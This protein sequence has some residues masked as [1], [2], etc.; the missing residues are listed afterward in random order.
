MAC[1]VHLGR[2]VDV[3][4]VFCL[5]VG[6]FSPRFLWIPCDSG[7]KPSLF[8]RGDD[9]D[10]L[11]SFKVLWR[12]CLSTFTVLLSIFLVESWVLRRF[13]RRLPFHLFVWSACFFGFVPLFSTVEPGGLTKR[14]MLLDPFTLFSYCGRTVGGLHSGGHC[15][16]WYGFNY[17]YGGNA[18]LVP[19]PGVRSVCRSGELCEV[20]HASDPS[21]F[22]SGQSWHYVL[23]GS[24]VFV[25][26]KNVLTFG[27]HRAA[28]EHFGFE[29]LTYQCGG[30]LSSAFSAA[31]SSGYDAVQFAYHEDAT[32]GSYLAEL[33]IRGNGSDVCSPHYVSS[34]GKRCACEPSLGYAN[35]GAGFYDG[36]LYEPPEGLLYCVPFGASFLLAS[37]IFSVH[38]FIKFRN[39]KN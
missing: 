11:W 19:S 12:L 29:C 20:M 34:N 22:S 13:L 32:C 16:V 38:R 3:S 17:R 14:V 31:W 36:P 6:L 26:P 15:R 24:G 30:N 25:R 28:A 39:K 7:G 10:V 5:G 35:C 2:A 1:A 33:V 4:L 27:T 21:D 8:R 23:P 37:V 9:P 18:V